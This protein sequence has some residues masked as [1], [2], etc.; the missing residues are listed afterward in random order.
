MNNYRFLS[1]IYTYVSNKKFLLYHY[2]LKKTRKGIFITTSYF[3]QSVYDYVKS[4]DPTIILI[5]GEQLTRIMIEYKVTVG[6]N[7]VFEIKRIDTD[8]FDE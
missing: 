8:Y 3:P 4:I 5:D 7:K 1:I 2:Y 6:K